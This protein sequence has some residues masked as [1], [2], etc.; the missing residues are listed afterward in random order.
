MTHLPHVFACAQFLL[1]YLLHWG[2]IVTVSLYINFTFPT[3]PFNLGIC[4]TS[5]R[6]H[7]RIMCR[8]LCVR[9]HSI[10]YCSLWISCYTLNMGNVHTGT[11]APEQASVREDWYLH[12]L[13]E[14]FTDFP[15]L[16]GRVGEKEPEKNE[17]DLLFCVFSWKIQMEL[18][19]CC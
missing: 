10:F 7:N 4:I 9:Y 5:L 1:K 13:V 15:R 14:V 17:P 3:C 11:S 8:L 19:S 12:I 16:K 18:E 6:I 2:F